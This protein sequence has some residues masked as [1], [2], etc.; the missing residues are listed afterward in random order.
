MD[1]GDTKTY[2]HTLE[3]L[4]DEIITEL[5][6]IAVHR[7]DT[8]DWVAKPASSGGEADDNVEADLVEDWNERR[9]TL[10]ELEIRYQNIKRALQ[11]I[12]A[13]TF[14][15]CEVSGE[16]IEADRLEAN[17]AA[18]TCKAHLEQEQDLPL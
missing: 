18:R 2:K 6:T 16:P 5:E 15:L 1:M 14:G 11:K 8:D 3:G 10:A 4:L 12:E 7:A 13:G 9:A 17:P